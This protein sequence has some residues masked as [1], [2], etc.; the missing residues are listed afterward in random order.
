MVAAAKTLAVD[1]NR[2]AAVAVAFFCIAINLQEIIAKKQLNT[3]SAKTDRD[4]RALFFNLFAPIVKIQ[5]CGAEMFTRLSAS[6]P[7]KT[8]K[9]NLF[10]QRS[11]RRTHGGLGMLWCAGSQKGGLLGSARIRVLVRLELP[12]S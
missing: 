5:K 3:S 2:R 10:A 6:V 9:G 11:T 12:S 8:P 7:E 1:E 4:Q